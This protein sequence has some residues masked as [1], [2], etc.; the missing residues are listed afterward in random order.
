MTDTT[1][2]HG[3]ELLEPFIPHSPDWALIKPDRH[4]SVPFRY[5]SIELKDAWRFVFL[6]RHHDR[7][8]SDPMEKNNTRTTDRPTDRTSENFE[9]AGPGG[10]YVLLCVNPI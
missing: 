1:T 6:M 10:V 9:E 8:V 3:T 5:L 4:D 7:C 2:R